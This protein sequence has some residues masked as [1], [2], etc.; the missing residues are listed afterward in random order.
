MG[1]RARVSNPF[2]CMVNWKDMNNGEKG[3]FACETNAKWNL[4]LTKR[5]YIAVAMLQGMLSGEWTNKPRELIDI[6][7]ELADE[8]LKKLES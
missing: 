4:G 7:V 3:A 5:E 8:L 2:L 1:I 6:S